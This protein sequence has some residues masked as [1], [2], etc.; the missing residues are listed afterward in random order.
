MII[1]SMIITLLAVQSAFDSPRSPRVSSNKHVHF[2]LTP[3]LENIT[4]EVINVTPHKDPSWCAALKLRKL[5]NNIIN[6]R[7]I[8]QTKIVVQKEVNANVPKLFRPIAKAWME[9]LN[10]AFMLFQEDLLS[11]KK[12]IDVFFGKQKNFD[13]DVTLRV[14]FEES[15]K[16]IEE[17]VRVFL[18]SL[19]LMRRDLDVSPLLVGDDLLQDLQEQEKMIMQARR[20]CIVQTFLEIETIE[21]EPFALIEDYL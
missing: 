17:A 19:K 20:S 2:P 14:E 1:I 11:K 16:D 6:R 5:L 4:C 10:E 12:Q 13:F 8:E 21:Y 7:W 15:L 3:N 18:I 9:E